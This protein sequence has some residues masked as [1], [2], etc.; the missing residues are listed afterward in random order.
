MVPTHHHHHQVS[1]WTLFRSSVLTFILLILPT[2]INASHRPTTLGHPKISHFALLPRGGSSTTTASPPQVH[3]QKDNDDE[4]EEEEEEI[5]IEQQQ[6]E[7]RLKEQKEYKAYQLQQQH[8]LQLRSTFLSE[9]LA[10]RGIKVGPT[11]MDVATPEGAAPPQPCDW[12]CC[13][14][15]YEDPKVGLFFVYM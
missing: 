6:K 4:E 7:Q 12:D 3:L 2:I 14:S 13:M 5:D 15:T 10:M 9:A 8:L 1:I 11:M